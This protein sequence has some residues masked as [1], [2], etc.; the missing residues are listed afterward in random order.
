MTGRRD[1]GPSAWRDHGPSAWRDHDDRPVEAPEPSEEAFYEE[2]GDHQGAAYDRNA[3]AR[4]TVHEVD[5]LWSRLSIH[6]GER[7][8]DVGCATGRH[9]REAV[10]RGVR[11]TGVDV[12]ARLVE[13]AREATPP[14]DHDA[15]RF[16]HHDARDLD[17]VVQ[18]ASF[19]VAWS[20]HHGALGTEPG[21]D[22]TIVNSMRRALRP[23]GRFALTLYHALSA[24]RNLVPGDAFDPVRLVHHQR[25]EVHA[26]DGRRRFDLWTVSYT[27]PGAVRLL[28]DV[29]LRVTAVVGAEPGR[30]D[31]G[32]VGLDDPELLLVGYRPPDGP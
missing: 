26:P 1:H 31:G 14:R 19:D 15:L 16:L 24:V 7:V 27:V 29:G 4:A 6:P 30:Y 12:S 3:F 5:A 13:A 25:S 28:E 10:T 2:I 23:G 20:L 17:A 9:L 18:P 8:L 11:G 32:G 21:R 22:A